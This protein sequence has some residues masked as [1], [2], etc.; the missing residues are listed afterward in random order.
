MSTLTK[1]YLGSNYLL[2]R[3]LYQADGSTPLLV[4]SCTSIVCELMQAGAVVATYTLTEGGAL[5]ESPDDTA[6][7][8]LELTVAALNALSPG[9][10]VERWTLTLANADFSASGGVETDRIILRKHTVA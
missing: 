8:V 3:P 2:E 4:A 5:R 1:L 6:T 10:L 9:A 7:A